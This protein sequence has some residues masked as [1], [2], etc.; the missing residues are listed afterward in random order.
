MGKERTLIQTENQ[1][2]REKESRENVKEQRV[3]PSDGSLG[4]QEN[5]GYRKQEAGGQLAT[6]GLGSRI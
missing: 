2:L 3:S 5:S 1:A 6:A 4:A